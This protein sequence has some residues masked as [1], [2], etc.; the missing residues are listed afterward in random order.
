MYRAFLA[1]ELSKQSTQAVCDL[2]KKLQTKFDDV[3]W[4]SEN[5]LHI[6]VRFLGSIE[7]DLGER[8]M[9]LLSQS[10]SSI[11]K[12]TALADKLWLL[13]NKHNPKALTLLLDSLGSFVK[14]NEGV[15]EILRI[16]NIADEERAYLPHITIAKTRN[17]FD[18]EDLLQSFAA[19][20]IEIDNVTLYKSDTSTKPSQYSIIKQVS[21]VC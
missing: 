8:I 12:F 1:V 17:H 5:N 7:N 16:E 18:L 21:L 4:V 11:K 9:D 6:T 20:P 10:L 2:M 19:I 13:P 3:Y 15:S 14:L